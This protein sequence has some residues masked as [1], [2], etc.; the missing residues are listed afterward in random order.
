MLGLRNDVV[1]SSDPQHRMLQWLMNEWEWTL[2]EA[3]VSYFKVL[4]WHSFEAADENH[5]N[6]NQDSQFPGHG[7]SPSPFEYM[8]EALS[9][10]PT[11]SVRQ[12]RTKETKEWKEKGKQT[13]FRLLN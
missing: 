11:F 6:L 5:V 9:P 12:K 10:K 4:S 7:S 3:V 1:N 13:S 8:S 2:K